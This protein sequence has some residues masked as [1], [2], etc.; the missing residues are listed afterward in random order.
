MQPAHYD[1]YITQA[2]ATDGGHLAIGHG[3]FSLYFGRGA[4]LS[5]Y[6]D[7][8][9]KAAC[10]AAGLPVID[11]RKVEFSTLARLV[12][13]GPMVAVGEPPSRPP[14]HAFSYAPLAI[15]AAAYRAAGAELWN[16]ER[17]R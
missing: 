5:G 14:Y 2:L 7:D 4:H 8:A 1:S 9:I 3:G 13:S 12:V 16:L 6:D 15:V 11:S 10:I 17:V